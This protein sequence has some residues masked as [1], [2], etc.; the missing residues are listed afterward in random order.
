MKKHEGVY[1][2]LLAGANG[3][4]DVLV[5]CDRT[6]CLSQPGDRDTKQKSEVT[7]PNCI[8]TLE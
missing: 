6:G 2:H 5:A 1:V 4:G 7:C 3:F 8:R